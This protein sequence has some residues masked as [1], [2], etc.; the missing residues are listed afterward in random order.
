[1]GDGFGAIDDGGL[2]Q[3]R[4]FPTGD[5]GPLA[6][7]VELEVG[8]PVLDGLHDVAGGLV[9][10]GE[11]VIGVGVLGV[12]AEGGVVMREGPETVAAFVVEVAEVE[13]GEGVVGVGFDGLAVLFFGQSPAALVEVDGSEVNKGPGGLRVQGDGL[14][15]GGD[16]V[17]DGSA[18]LFEVEAALE[19]VVGFGALFAEIL[20]GAAFVAG[21]R[22]EFFEGGRVEIEEEL[23]GDGIHLLAGEMDA[24]AFAVGEDLEFD[25]RV[26][27]VLEAVAERLEATLDAS[28]GHFLFAQGVEGAK[29]DEVAEAVPILL[30]DKAL[31]FPTPEMT[32][33][34]RQYASDLVAG[35]R[36]LSN[37]VSV[38][39]ITWTAVRRLWKTTKYCGLVRL[40]RYQEYPM[41]QDTGHK[42]C[43][44]RQHPGFLL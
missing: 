33:R 20:D 37:H 16:G 13:L 32:L 22:A 6:G 34:Y 15:V 14:F 31:L 43:A 39:S 24:D 29:G 28:D 1:M 21:E 42:G 7:R 36:L 40:G 9:E 35:P 27:D 30:G 5:A 17:G 4:E 23:A 3:L 25:E 2:L 12:E 10:Q 26:G 44:Q 38:S 41:R 18:G 19:P 11:V 8:A